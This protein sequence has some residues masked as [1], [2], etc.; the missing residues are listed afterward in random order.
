MD[1]EKDLQQK[2]DF[3]VETEKLN[4]VIDIIAKEILILV[5]K[6]KEFATYIVD[7]R[8]KFIEEYKDDEDRLMEFFDHE[9]YVKEEAYKS[10][11]RK[12]KELTILKPIPYFGKIE[13]SEEDF[14]IDTIYIGRFGV[15]PQDGLEPVVID[16]R[17]PVSS[18]FYE[19]RLGHVKYTAPAG[20]IFVNILAKRQYIIKNEELKGMFNSDMD[21]KDDI[22]QMVLSKNAGE[23][24][25]DIIMTIQKE[26]DD[27]IRDGQYKV[28]VVDGVAGSGKTTIA[29]HRV[30]YLLYNHRK[31]LEDNVLIIGPNKIFMEYISSVLP[32][33]GETGVKQSTYKELGEYILG[34]EVMP[35]KEYMESI[36]NGDK[37]ILDDVTHKTSDL[38]ISQLDNLIMKLEE[39]FFKLQ[40]I[41]FE[42]KVVI[43]SQELMELFKVHYKHM[44]LFKRSKKIKRIVFSRLKDRRDEIVREINEAYKKEEE[45]LTPEELELQGTDLEY[46]RKNEIRD[47]IRK[48]MDIKKDLG[49]INSPNIISIYKDFN[50]NKDFILDDLAAIIY[51]KV[52]LEGYK[53]EEQIKHLVVDE[54]QD[55]SKLQLLVLREITKCNSMTILGDKNQRIIPTN[56]EIAFVN[57]KNIYTGVVV[58]NYKLNKSYRSTKEI[59]EYANSILKDDNIIPLVRSGEPVIEQN[60]DSKENLK[61][62]L[63]KKIMDFKEKGYDS[64]GIIGKN[65]EQCKE[66]HNM[67]KSNINIRL[68]DNE[69]LIYESGMIVIPSYYAK[70]LE[71]DAVIAIEEDVEKDV[72]E[73][74]KLRYVMATRALHE[75]CVYKTK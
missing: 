21:I 44:P 12:L 45:K 13:F 70:G 64:I 9:R 27:I 54:A 5:E 26:Q 53:L 51:L 38:F 34:L 31:Q 75:L 29:L 3:E 48:L 37:E 50:N 15:V 59:M 30:A 41:I 2:I 24:L 40:D 10:I 68:L 57:L 25:K 74:R 20:E 52:K 17:A 47:V 6:R 35:Y 73:E 23:K 11:D 58:S 67:L 43:T 49:F 19:G 46:K 55:L 66:I 60:I 62:S 42:E 61:E 65:I 36:L 14:G 4:Q 8:K 32:T 28:V 63:L 18:L 1:F 69:N 7:Y 72:R 16:W 33:L 22:L 56:D 39:N 71:F